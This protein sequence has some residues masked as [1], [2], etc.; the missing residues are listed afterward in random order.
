MRGLALVI[1]AVAGQFLGDARVEADIEQGRTILVSAKVLQ[2]DKA[3]ARVVALVAKDAIQFQRMADGFVDLQHHLVRHQQQVGGAARR[4]GRVQQ[5]QGFVR[6][7]RCSVSEAQARDD[8][9]AALLAATEAAE[10]AGLAVVAVEGGHADAGID[11]AQRL[12]LLGTGA[13]EVELL[14]AL[15]IE[16]NQPVHQA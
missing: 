16:I 7:P 4:I 6:H 3:G 9:R 14:K 1:K 12:P 8:L 15:V 2:P 5:L 13:I 10:A 11:E